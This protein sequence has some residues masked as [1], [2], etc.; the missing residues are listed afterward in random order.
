[1]RELVA[2]PEAEPFAVPVDVED[3]PSVVPVPMDLGLILRRLENVRRL[4][5]GGR[6]GRGGRQ[7]RLGG[8]REGR[9][10]RGRLGGGVGGGEEGSTGLCCSGRFGEAGGGGIGGLGGR[11]GWNLMC[12]RS[13][14]SREVRGGGG[15]RGGGEEFACF[16]HTFTGKVIFFGVGIQCRELP[17]ERGGGGE[18]GEG[19][20]LATPAV[21][22]PCFLGVGYR[23]GYS[24]VW[25]ENNHPR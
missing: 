9:D 17:R 19:A 15:E 4:W 5:C 6:K 13:E 8:T 23:Y 24:R 21:D 14:F 2:S 3:Y 25:D 1:M 16:M 22:G 18:K 7:G 10:G 11:M 12:V 20:H